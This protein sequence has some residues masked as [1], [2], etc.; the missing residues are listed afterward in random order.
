[1]MTVLLTGTTGFIG[2]Y[3]LN[4]LER[5]GT[6]CISLSRGR[7]KPSQGVN[8]DLLKVSDAGLLKIIRDINATHLIH[9]AWYTEHGKYWDASVNIEWTL[10]SS[11]LV[12]AFCQ[13][14]GK[15]VLIA[16]TCAEYDWRYGYC[17]ED[18]TPLKP[19]TLYGISK[20]TTR[21]IASN[22][23]K[24]HSVPFA[25]AR[26]FFPYGVGESSSRLIPSLF[27]AFRSGGPYFGVN[28]DL[29]RDFLHVRDV[30][31]ALA[32]CS[33][34][35][36]VGDINICSGEPTT[37]RQVTE[38]VAEICGGE[39]DR[40]LALQSPRADEPRLL[41]GDN[42]RLRGLGWS[43]HISLDEGLL[44]YLTEELSE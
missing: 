17:I 16:G 30:A 7:R 15:H 44:S 11:R 35:R 33:E 13:S 24:N 38:K 4:H 31:N 34:R 29:Y 39:S 36:S 12:K 18:L 8:V 3:V 25:W 27:R 2:S 22:I 5:N 32:L 41:V 21:E 19:G 43:Q 9:L 20:N 26:I 40:V 37:I 28:T 23:C 6:H 1:M 42:A 10:A 14:G